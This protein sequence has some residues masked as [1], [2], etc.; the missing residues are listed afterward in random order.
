MPIKKRVVRRK[1]VTAPVQAG[2]ET[3]QA[4]IPP[5]PPKGPSNFIIA[6]LIVVSFFAGYL[7][8]KVKNLE[9]KNV[10]QNQQNQ[11]QQQA[12]APTELKIKKPE[13]NEHWRGP[14]DVRYVWVEYSDL[15]CPF[16]K[17]NHPD[18]QKLLKEYEG[19]IAW[20]YRH[21]PLA[22]HPKAQKS[23]EAVECATE[24]GGNDAFWKMTDLIFEKMPDMQLADLPSIAGQAGL[25]QNAL[26][27]CL[28]S[29][30]FEQQVKN[31]S[32][33]GNQ[34]GVRATP[35]GVIYDL[36]TGKTQ[37]VEG[38]YPYDSLKQSLDAFM[39]KNK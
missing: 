22:F 4:M 9:Q 33:E 2:S 36:K 39:A 3:Y 20:V 37:V 28:D 27:S 5:P 25:D 8:F 18:L 1:K 12:Q 15:E 23:A 35:T 21:F 17:K 7:F 24:L 14:K 16:C 29:N 6:L 32:N 31:Q 34:A 13:T 10:V 11:P 26:K 30:K 19:K 38:A